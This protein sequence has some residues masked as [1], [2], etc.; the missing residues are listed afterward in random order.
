M[1]VRTILLTTFLVAAWA[2]CLLPAQTSPAQAPVVKADTIF[3]HG[4]F[5]TAVA[6]TSSFQEIQRAEALAVKDDVFLP[7]AKLMTS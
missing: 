2:T 6:G 7:P 1:R 3:V 5:Y 4:N